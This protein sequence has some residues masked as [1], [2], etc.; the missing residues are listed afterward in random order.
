MARKHQY[1]GTV[2][3]KCGGCVTL[4]YTRDEVA[5]FIKDARN[6]DHA[7]VITKNGVH[8]IEEDCDI[9]SRF[10]FTKKL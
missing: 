9:V 2:V 8:T 5:S 4:V 6:S 1:E 10:S 7:T 3:T